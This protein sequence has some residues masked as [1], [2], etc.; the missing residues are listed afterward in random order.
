MVARS[1]GEIE[2]LPRPLYDYVQHGEASLD[3]RP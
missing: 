1:L 3:H 2:F